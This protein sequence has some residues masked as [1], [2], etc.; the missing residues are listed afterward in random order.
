[1]ALIIID[2]GHGGADPGARYHDRLEKDD[3][4]ALAL[5][6][7]RILEQNGQ[8]VYYTRT[9]DIYEAPARRAQEGNAVRGDYFV[10]IHRNSS[11]YPNQYSGVEALVYSRYGQAA[12]LAY[13]INSRLEELG[14]Q[15]LGVN[16]R[17][18]LV[19]LNRTQMPAVLLEAGF[20]NTDGD[21][22]LL[23]ERFDQIA[24]AIA[25]G[26]LAAARGV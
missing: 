14:F 13:Q 23:D 6:V 9:T 18:E 19:V 12:G 26:I 3:N 7:G 11:T 25:E 22:R 20:I 21:N 4:L 2:A 16:Q 1:M 17:P 5:A 15:N 24:Q 8:E 10:S